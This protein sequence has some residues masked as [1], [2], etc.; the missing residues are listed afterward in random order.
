MRFHKKKLRVQKSDQ[1]FVKTGTRKNRGL[2]KHCA[3]SV[4]DRIYGIL[5]SIEYFTGLGYFLNSVWWI[6][7]VNDFCER[8]FKT[9]AAV[10]RFFFHSFLLRCLTKLSG[11][12]TL[13]HN[14]QCS[15]KP[16]FSPVPVFTNFCILFKKN[17]WNCWVYS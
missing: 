6:L 17:L 9:H 11:K 4:F 2:P 14:A 12:Q 8:A 16:I 3:M 7:S 15:G 1:K 5:D 10:W 13:N